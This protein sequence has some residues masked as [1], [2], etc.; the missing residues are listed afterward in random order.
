MA[1]LILDSGAVIGFTRGN[2][3]VAAAIRIAVQRGEEVVVPPVVVAETIRGDR[4]DAPVHRL[5]NAVRVTFAGLRAGRVVGELLGAAGMSNA[6][7]AL[8]MAES[9]R[10]GSCVLLTSDVDDMSRL[11]AG[12]PSVTIMAV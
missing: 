11:A 7:D 2:H 12:R 8:V 3:D 4:R 5:L 6:A 10:G 1:R 9:I